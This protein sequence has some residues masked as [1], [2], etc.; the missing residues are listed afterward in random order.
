MPDVK[1]LAIWSGPPNTIF[2]ADKKITKFEDMEAL[3]CRCGGG[4]DPLIEAFG[5]VPVFMP[6]TETYIALQK[7]I[8][9]ATTGNYGH[10]KSYKLGEVYQYSLSK[11]F[12]ISHFWLIINKDKW[13]SLPSDIQDVMD[14]VRPWFLETMGGAWDKSD[15]EGLEFAAPLGHEVL[16]LSDAEWAKFNQAV[17]PLAEQWITDMEAQGYADAKQLMEKKNEIVAQYG[18]L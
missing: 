17:E 1:T 4:T 9:N 18:G 5:M 6:F 3:E 13:E 7:N 14:G 10:L 2:F 8:V 15:S 11:G 16:N 12:Y